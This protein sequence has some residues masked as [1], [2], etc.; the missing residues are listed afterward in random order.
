MADFIRREDALKVLCNNYAYAAMDVIKRL[1]AAD[2]AEVVRCKYCRHLG[3]PFLADATIAKNICC[4]IADLMIFAATASIRQIQEV[5]IMWLID[6]NRLY[7]AAEEKY[8]EDRSKTE[9]VITRVMLSQAR[10]KI[11]E[12][13]AYA[14]SVD[15]EPVVRCQD[16]KNF[17]RNEENDPYCADRRGLSDPEPDGYCSY[18]ERREE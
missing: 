4:R 8:M 1:P 5:A 15:A 2:V 12:L 13:I 9:N 14:P 11:Q 10:Q 3:H 6:A 16:C 7:D 17:R 18:G